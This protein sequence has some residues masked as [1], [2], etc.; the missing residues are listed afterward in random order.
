MTTAE[1][2]FGTKAGIVWQ[3]LN[4]HGFLGMP[5]IISK[6][7]LTQNQIY[8]ALGWL[9]REGKINVHGK[10]LSMKFELRK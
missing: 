2:Y 10:G 3:A 7:K 6:T 8:A 4:D 1:E 5:Q 9:A